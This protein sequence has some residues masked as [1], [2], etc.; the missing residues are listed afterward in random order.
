MDMLRKTTKLLAGLAMMLFFQ[1][2]L[3]AQI[4]FGPKVGYQTS[5]IRYAE[6]Y[7]GS[8][9]TDGMIF[10]PQVGATYSFRL[11][12][13]LSF[14]SELYYA[15]RGKKERTNDLTTLMRN[16]SASYHFLEVP[17]MIRVEH[18]LSKSKK[19][20]RA[21]VNLGP[22]VGLWMAG[23][24]N[25]ESL[26]TFG[27]TNR[28]RSEYSIDFSGNE[29]QENIL[30]A[31]DANRLHF[32]LNAGTGLMIPMN[33]KGQLLQIDFRYTYGSTFLG[34]D[35]D[36]EIGTTGVEENYSFGHSFAAVSVAYAFYL[37]IW[38]MRKGKSIRRR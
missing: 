23:R 15:Q 33:S 12:K 25:L 35:L 29:G 26:E 37:D 16:H 28:R 20:A 30:F 31:E 7:D 24:G 1:Q 6:L 14:Y 34:S 3:E 38:G 27:S 22:H 17:L 10:S 13:A 32:G 11:T 9:Y 2:E 19:S 4:L 5:W 18:P 8:D 36:L 21:Y